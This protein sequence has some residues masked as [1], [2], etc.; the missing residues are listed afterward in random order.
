MSFQTRFQPVAIVS[1]NGHVLRLYMLEGLGVDIQ[2]VVYLN[3]PNV[4]PF[5]GLSAVHKQEWEHV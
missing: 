4:L 2:V 3:L 1:Y 5:C